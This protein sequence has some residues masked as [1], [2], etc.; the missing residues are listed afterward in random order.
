M[1]GIGEHWSKSFRFHNGIWDCTIVDYCYRINAG[2]RNC[3]SFIQLVLSRCNSLLFTEYL[4]F[5][6]SLTVWCVVLYTVFLNPYKLIL[7]NLMYFY[8]TMKY[9]V[10][11]KIV[12][13]L[14]KIQCVKYVM[15]SSDFVPLSDSDVIFK[16]PSRSVDF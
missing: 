4:Q 5:W 2:L 16:V 3:H 13:C 11:P 9:A 15:E 6:W 14:I 1:F 7:L 12:N 8:C 10:V